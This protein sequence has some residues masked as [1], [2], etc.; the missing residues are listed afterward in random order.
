MENIVSIWKD[1]DMYVIFLILKCQ[2]I[3][4]IAIHVFYQPI[5]TY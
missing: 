4:L 5:P 1:Y 3:Q 2:G